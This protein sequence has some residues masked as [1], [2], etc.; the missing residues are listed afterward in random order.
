MKKDYLDFLYENRSKLQ[1]EIEMLVRRKADP[2]AK[3]CVD[4][5]TT[6]P[7]ELQLKATRDNIY[8]INMC[9][10]KYMELH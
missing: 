2:R 6:S 5:D 9:I 10:E 3:C 4:M 8:S 7:I 1:A